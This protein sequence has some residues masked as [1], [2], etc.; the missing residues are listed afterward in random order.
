[1]GLIIKGSSSPQNVGTRVASDPSK[2]TITVQEWVANQDNLEGYVKESILS[3]KK[4]EYSKRTG[5]AKASVSN[6]GWIGNDDIVPVVT[7]QLV[8]V[9]TLTPTSPL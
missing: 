6:P 8:T 1:M 3:G 5:Y 9:W 4:V 2:G 7:W